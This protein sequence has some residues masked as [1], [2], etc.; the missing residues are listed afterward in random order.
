MFIKIRVS[1]WKFEGKERRRREKEERKGGE[2][3]RRREMRQATCQ[4]R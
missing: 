1:E 2:K 3:G 4:R